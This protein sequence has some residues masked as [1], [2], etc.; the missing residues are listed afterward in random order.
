MANREANASEV[1]VLE[2]HLQSGRMVWQEEPR[3]WGTYQ[4]KDLE[5][6]SKEVKRAKQWQQ[7]YE[8]EH[9]Q[10]GLEKFSE[11]YNKDAM[12]LGVGDIVDT[13]GKGL[14]KGKLGKGKASK[15]KGKGKTGLLALKDK[16]EEPE[17][18]REEDTLEEALKKARKARDSVAKTLNDL[19]EALEKA[20]DK[21]SRQGNATAT[22]LGTELGKVLTQLKAVLEGK[23]KK[24]Q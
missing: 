6:W 8:F 16:E 23:K 4:H 21:L 11:L 17:G 10:E 2:L 12:H 22:G 19:E 20:K 15:G 24:P 7:G 14:G 9:D 18:E 1:H 13:P 3:T 5:D